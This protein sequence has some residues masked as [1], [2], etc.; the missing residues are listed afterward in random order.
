MGN[1]HIFVGCADGIVHVFKTNGLAFVA[2]LPRPHC[3][4]L[5]IAT[6]TLNGAAMKYAKYPDA[7]AIRYDETRKKLTCVYNDHSLYQW[8]IQDDFKRVGKTH[9]TLAHGGCIWSVETYPL[10]AQ[11]LPPGTFFTGGSDDTIR[12]W[13]IDPNMPTDTTGIRKNV[14]SSELLKIIYADPQLA[15]LCDTE[16]AIGKCQLLAL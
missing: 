4:G 13:N 2:T 15:H 6:A 10:A 5:D 3:L 8:E 12:V 16:L 1:G 9:S 11:A 14:Y 7:V